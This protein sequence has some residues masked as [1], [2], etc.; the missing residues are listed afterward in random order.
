M[1]LEKDPDLTNYDDEITEEILEQH[2][3]HILNRERFESLAAG[4]KLK[5]KLTK[6]KKSQEAEES[7]IEE[8]PKAKKA[9]K[10]VTF[11]FTGKAIEIKPIRTEAL[12]KQM[13]SVHQSVSK[14][15]S[16]SRAQAAKQ[17]DSLNAG[18]PIDLKT[19][20]FNRMR[21]FLPEKL[22]QNKN[23]KEADPLD[24]L[25]IGDFIDVQ[26]GVSYSGDG[27]PAKHQIQESDSIDYDF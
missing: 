20:D 19:I 27:R 15:Q 18:P 16:T 21:A 17:R 23:I 25:R 7:V 13:V 11:S 4:P 10:N 14:G 24:Q 3:T 9:L 2:R 1:R 6:I 8:I 26:S 22:K 5:R 12:P